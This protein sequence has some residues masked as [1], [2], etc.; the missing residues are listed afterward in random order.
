VDMPTGTRCTVCALPIC[1]NDLVIRGERAWV[2]G[3]C[4][5]MEGSVQG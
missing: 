4:W 5:V 1:D 2:H 3:A